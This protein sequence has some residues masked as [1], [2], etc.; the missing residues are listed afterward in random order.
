MVKDLTEFYKHPQM[1]DGH[2]NKCK[3]CAKEDNRPCNGNYGRKCLEC[4]KQFFT[5]KTEIERRGGGG[6][7]CSRKCYFDRFRKIVKRD[8]KSPNWKGD[9]V[10]KTALH[11]WVERKLGKPMKC[12]HCLRTGCKKYE[13]A[14][15]SQ[16]Y[17]RDIADWLRLCT[18]CHAKYDYNVRTKKWAVAVRKLGWNV[19][20]I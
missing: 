11:N 20:K 2:L 3:T 9:S 14:N 18:R 7:T 17:K 15:K 6:K 4:G 13:W 19:T 8:E 16:K 12:E 10:G 5:T 1:G